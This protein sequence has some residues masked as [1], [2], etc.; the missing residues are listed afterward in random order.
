MIH[1]ME[2]LMDDDE[3]EYDSF[4]PQR[5]P[6]YPCAKS[7]L[8]SIFMMCGIT[9]THEGSPLPSL[10]NWVLL[11][12]RI[13]RL[14]WRFPPSIGRVFYTNTLSF[15]ISSFDAG[16]RPPEGEG[17]GFLVKMSKP[18]WTE[19][20]FRTCCRCFRPSTK[21][22]TRRIRPHLEWSPSPG[23]ISSK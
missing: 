12:R 5:Q 22:Q 20:C 2:P 14:A 10:G 17:F 7:P 3:F 23:S 1:T 13:F 9:S 6:L 15:L 16:E 4:S 8:P 21:G 18:S 11:K 19:L